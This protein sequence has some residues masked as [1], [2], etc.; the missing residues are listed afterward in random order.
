M[1]G[2]EAVRSGEI[3]IEVGEPFDDR[4]LRRK[5]E[6]H[7]GPRPEHERLALAGGS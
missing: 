1:I 4:R 7:V 5:N 6:C 3:G 2:K